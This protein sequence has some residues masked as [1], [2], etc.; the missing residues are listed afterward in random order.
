[1]S[2]AYEALGDETD[3]IASAIRAGRDPF[4]LTA[5]QVAALQRRA[6]RTAQRK[7]VRDRRDAARNRAARTSARSP[8]A[9]RGALPSTRPP[10][11]SAADPMISGF[12]RVRWDNGR[13][14]VD[15]AGDD[16]ADVFMEMMSARGYDVTADWVEST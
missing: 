4:A 2:I 3:R 15:I 12:W 7:N 10:P 14:W 5:E 8:S 6:V 11:T 13:A 16:D 9:A 1:M